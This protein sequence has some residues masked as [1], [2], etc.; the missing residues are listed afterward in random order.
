MSEW[1]AWLA[2]AER[3]EQGGREIIL[4]AITR[5][6]PWAAT[7]IVNGTI[8][9]SGTFTA[10]IAAAPDSAPLAACAVTAAYLSGDN[11]SWI[12]LNLNAVQTAALPADADGD[13][14]V[15][16]VWDLLHTPTTGGAMRIAASLVPV[17]GAVTA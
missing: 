17:S 7:L 8:A 1:D 15:W 6:H 16:L 12:T 10:A 14:L 3:S 9:L 13:G 4:P 2:E 5:G 11:V